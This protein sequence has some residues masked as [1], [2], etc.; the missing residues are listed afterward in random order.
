MSEV[1]LVEKL[2]HT[3]SERMRP[4]IPLAV[5][6]WGHRDSGAIPQARYRSGTGSS[7]IPGSERT[8]G[9]SLKIIR[10]RAE[11]ALGKRR[12]PELTFGQ[13]FHQE[14]GQKAVCFFRADESVDKIVNPHF[15]QQYSLAWHFVPRKP[16]NEKEN[17]SMIRETDEQ[18]AAGGAPALSVVRRSLAASVYIRFAHARMFFLTITHVN[19]SY[20]GLEAI[21]L[22]GFFE[23]VD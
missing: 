22:V 15:A 21:S 3:L 10:F 17:P 19:G 5:D 6:L 16:L 11:F 9:S 1:E 12:I 20:A 18:I 8:L 23:C 4:S 2:A 13:I 7:M 14:T